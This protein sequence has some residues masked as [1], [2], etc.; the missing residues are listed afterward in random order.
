MFAFHSRW[1]TYALVA[2]LKITTKQ[3]TL[4]SQSQ[5]E[6]MTVF[7]PFA[8]KPLTMIALSKKKYLS[9]AALIQSLNLCFS[10]AMETQAGAAPVTPFPTMV[11]SFLSPNAYFM[12]AFMNQVCHSTAVEFLANSGCCATNSFSAF[13]DCVG[14]HMCTVQTS[15]FVSSLPDNNGA[16]AAGTCPDVHH[17]KFQGV[18][19]NLT[20]TL[21][22]AAIAPSLSSDES[23]SIGSSLGL[24]VGVVAAYYVLTAM[25]SASKKSAEMPGLLDSSG[26]EF[27]KYGTN[28]LLYAMYSCHMYTHR[29]LLVPCCYRFRAAILSSKLFLT[30]VELLFL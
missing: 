11:R 27:K 29:I 4:P 9:T 13:D 23:S 22:T 1:V 25:R 2:T 19:K 8:S 16:A 6:T 14:Q 28:L 5:L 12:H 17:G 26:V 21:S 30:V 7:R 24:M 18:C 15:V 20:T 10:L 3:K